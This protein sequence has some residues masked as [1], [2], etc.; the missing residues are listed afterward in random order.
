[1]SGGSFFKGGIGRIH[2]NVRIYLYVCVC[3]VV[4]VWLCVCGC[5]CVVVYT[6]MYEN[7]LFA[8]LGLEVAVVEVHRR[9]VRVL[10]GKWW[11]D[12]WMDGWM[13]EVHRQSQAGIFI[14][15]LID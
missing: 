11:M 6:Y 9:A 13:V 5:V 15:I 10:P 8:H 14:F 7:L 4:C 1:M 3:V 12:G 2:V